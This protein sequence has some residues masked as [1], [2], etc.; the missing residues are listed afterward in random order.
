MIIYLHGFA[1]SGNS[2]KVTAL[3]ERFGEENVFA[4]DLP[5]DPKAVGVL[6]FDALYKE[7]IT[8]GLQMKNVVFVGT[9]LGAFYATYFS[10]FF[11]APAVIVNPSVRPHESLSSKVGRNINHATKEE[12]WLSLIDLAA[13]K[14]MRD[15]I[16]ENYD[17]KLLHLFA[18]KDDE[19]VPCEEVLA[20]YK[21]TAS[22]T[23]TETGKHRYT[24]HW[25]LV[26]DKIA[27]LN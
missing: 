24:E 26:M 17:G 15:Y 7:F 1:S 12:F 21:H 19:V 16:V 4:P 5:S 22:T 14:E 9:S 8:N 6:I 2:D 10:L 18:A 11:D 20:W 27:E 23:V 13:F 3:K 25:N